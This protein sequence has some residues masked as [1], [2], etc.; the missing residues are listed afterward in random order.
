MLA[1]GGVTVA[2]LVTGLAEVAV[3]VVMVMVVVLIVVIVA[4]P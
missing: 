1:V 4:T 3:I 2:V